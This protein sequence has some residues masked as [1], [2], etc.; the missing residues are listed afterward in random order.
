MDGKRML[1]R[2]ALA[3]VASLICM[4]GAAGWAVND[5][6]L[7]EKWAPS[8]FGKDDK[9]GAANRRTAASV[10][11]AVKLVKKGKVAAGSRNRL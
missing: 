2:S 7:K 8:E 4:Y 1:R 5:E 3:G 9:A 11:K 10:L 6:P